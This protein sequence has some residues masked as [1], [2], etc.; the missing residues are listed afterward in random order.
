MAQYSQGKNRHFTAKSTTSRKLNTMKIIHLILIA[1]LSLSTHAIAD[2]PGE[3]KEGATLPPAVLRALSGK[4]ATF[5]DY[6]GKPLIVNVWASWCGPCRSEMS[7]LENVSRRFGG[8][9]LNVIGISTDDDAYAAAAYVKEAKLSFNNY[10]DN[11]VILENML[12]ANTIPLTVLVDARGR[13]LLKIHGSQTWDSP[14]ALML[15]AKTFKIK[16]Q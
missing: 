6:R 16:L 1:L 3:I 2:T 14:E 7:S 11:N 13:V 4:A 15:I 12:G 8:K 10:I 9:Q 5:S